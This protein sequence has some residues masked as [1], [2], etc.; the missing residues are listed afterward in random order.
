MHGASKHNSASSARARAPV[1]TMHKSLMMHTHGAMRALKRASGAVRPSFRVMPRCHHC[2]NHNRSARRASKH[3]S[4]SS[5]R[6]RAPAAT[7]HKSLMMHTHGA[8]RAPKRASGAV[9][10]SLE[11]CQAATT[12]RIITAQAAPA[13][14]AANQTR[15]CACRHRPTSTHDANTRSHASNYPNQRARSGHRSRHATPQSL[16]EP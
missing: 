15:A 4:A 11:S 10:P 13:H 2:S 7:M 3:N 16:L 6:G 12:A 5:A 1:G 14:T 8:V 9:R